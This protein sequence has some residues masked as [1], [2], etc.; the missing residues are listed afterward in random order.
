[1]AKIGFIQKQFRT[2][3][4]NV[5]KECE[6]TSF[7]KP[8]NRRNE[9]LERERVNFLTVSFPLPP[10]L[11]RGEEGDPCPLQKL[12]CPLVPV[13]YEY[14]ICSINYTPRRLLYFFMIRVRRLFEGGVHLK[15]NSF[16]TNN[17]KFLSTNYISKSCFSWTVL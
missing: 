10:P 14:R 12:S 2:R 6:F 1:M 11:P 16:L 8:E 13:D 4:F 9:L 7:S 17:S 3:I 5:S 15:A